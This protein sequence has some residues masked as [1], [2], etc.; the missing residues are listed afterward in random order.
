MSIFTLIIASIGIFAW[1]YVI[2]FGI[3]QLIEK[4]MGKPSNDK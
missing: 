2:Y 4:K 1:S 3:T